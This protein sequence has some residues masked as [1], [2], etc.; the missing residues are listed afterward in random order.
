MDAVVELV[1]FVK[2]KWRF[3]PSKR[4]NHL[5]SA[6]IFHIEVLF[7]AKRKQEINFRDNQIYSAAINILI[8][9]NSYPFGFTHW[10]AKKPFFII[11]FSTILWNFFR[12][13]LSCSFGAFTWKARNIKKWIFHR[14][15]YPLWFCG[16]VTS[17]ETWA[18]VVGIW[19]S[20]SCLKAIPTVPSPVT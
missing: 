17:I 20:E 2:C 9:L 4:T 6:K 7:L 11:N 10:D 12:S 14:W 13:S 15:Y 5:F 18:F 16:G 8:S 3:R 1:F 19:H